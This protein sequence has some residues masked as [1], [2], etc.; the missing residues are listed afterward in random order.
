MES[1]E[2]NDYYWLTVEFDSS[3]ALDGIVVRNG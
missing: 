3:Y 1:A 2:V